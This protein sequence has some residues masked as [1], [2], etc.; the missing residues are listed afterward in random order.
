MCPLI[1]PIKTEILGSYFT[2]IEK[3]A[4]ILFTIWKGDFMGLTVILFHQQKPLNQKYQFD[5]S[6]IYTIGREIDCS[7]TIPK[8]VNNS[9]SR[10]HCQIVLKNKEVFVRDAGSSNGT[11]I[12]GTKLTDGTAHLDSNEYYEATDM[13]IHDGDTLMLGNDVFQIKIFSATADDEDIPQL[14][15]T[16][17]GTIILPSISG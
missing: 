3:N 13:H 8:T 11:N 5:T 14:T 7:L 9:L 2:F 16:K 4:I 10:H 12:N 15:T 1:H 17:A 6:G